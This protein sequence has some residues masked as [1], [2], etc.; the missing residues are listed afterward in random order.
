MSRMQDD[1]EFF[2]LDMRHKPKGP[3]DGPGPIVINHALMWDLLEPLAW[4]PKA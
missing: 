4:I 3:R 2:L 1:A